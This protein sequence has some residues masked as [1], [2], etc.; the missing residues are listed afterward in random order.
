VVLHRPGH[1]R[2]ERGERGGSVPHAV[3]RPPHAPPSASSFICTSGRS[4]APR[5]R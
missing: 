2:G 4:A 1:R 5:S 3:A